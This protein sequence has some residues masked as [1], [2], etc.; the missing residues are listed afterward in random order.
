[1]SYKFDR[2]E[3]NLTWM[4]SIVIAILALL[5]TILTGWVLNVIDVINTVGGDF[6][7]LLFVRIIGMLFPP[8]GAILGLFT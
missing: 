5:G 1:M 8:L 3:P 6:T 2:S 4:T 7:G